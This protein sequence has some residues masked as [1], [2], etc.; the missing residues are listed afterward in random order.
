MWG[1]LVVSVPSMPPYSVAIAARLWTSKALCLPLYS[2]SWLSTRRSAQLER[3][4][5]KYRTLEDKVRFKIRF[6]TANFIPHE[7]ETHCQE[8]WVSTCSLEHFKKVASMCE[9]VNYIE[10]VPGSMLSIRACLRPETKGVRRIRFTR[11]SA[12]P[13]ASSPRS[14]LCFS[15]N[16]WSS[17]AFCRASAGSH[18]GTSLS[19]SSSSAVDDS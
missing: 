8:C 14:A 9:F 1:S 18:V 11:T 3:W 5:S 10:E 6:K 7:L 16:R 19:P 4:R 15:T 12:E 2:A 17:H 13:T